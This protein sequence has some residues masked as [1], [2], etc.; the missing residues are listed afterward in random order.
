MNDRFAIL[1]ARAA[2]AWFT[3]YARLGELLA[4]GCPLHQESLVAASLEQFGCKVSETLTADF[5]FVRQSG[6]GL[7]LVREP[8]E[9]HELARL[10]A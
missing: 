4:L 9:H 2:E 6:E 10:L 7:Q 3:T 5:S 8:F 1:G